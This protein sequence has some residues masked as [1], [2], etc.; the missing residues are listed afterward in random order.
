ME[1]GWRARTH[2]RMR[3]EQ[4]R[5]ATN[6]AAWQVLD[7][8]IVRRSALFGVWVRLNARWLLLCCC[9]GVA[10]CGQK[11]PL[12]L[13]PDEAHAGEPPSVAAAARIAG[14]GAAGR[15]QTSA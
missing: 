6:T 1:V 10:T 8:G 15:K 2:A 11:G 4:A 14:A 13:P 7:T 9:A 5:G 3:D 12:A